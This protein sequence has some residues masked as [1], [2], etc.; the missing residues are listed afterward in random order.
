[1][2]PRNHSREARHDAAG[3]GEPPGTLLYS[4]D[5][6][7]ELTTLSHRTIW[8]LCKSGE[9]PSIKVGSRRL[10]TVAGLNAWLEAKLGQKGGTH[11]K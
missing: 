8:S 5:K 2:N 4:L 6:V 11:A 9:L 7:A 1:M 10:V 3:T